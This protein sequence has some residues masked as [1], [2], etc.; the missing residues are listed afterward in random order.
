M[1]IPLSNTRRSMH[2]RALELSRGL[3]PT[4]SNL[5]RVAKEA[6]IEA[7]RWAFSQWDLRGRAR[8]K[9]ARAEEMLFVRE[10]LEQATHERV[11]QYHAAC[12]PPDLQVLDMTTGIGADLIA[13]ARRG[14]AIGYELD[15]ERAELARHNVS[16]HGL[17]VN[18]VTADSTGAIAD[19]D[20]VFVDPARRV[21][22]RRT[23]VLE[24]FAPNPV[25]LAPS[26]A[27]RKLA[28]IKLSPMIKDE[29]LRSLGPAVEFIS[30]GGECREALVLCGTEAGHGFSAVH[31]AS[32][33]RLS[34]SD[35]TLPIESEPGEFIYDADPAAVR[36]HALATLAERHRLGMVGDSNGYLTGPGPITS[37]W[38]RTYRVR[39]A[40]K[41]DL[42]RTRAALKEL[43]AATPEIKQRGA[44]LDLLKERKAYTADGNRPVSLIVYPVG[45][46]LRHVVAEP[47]VP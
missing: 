16:V 36:A 31:I 21:D 46:S 41:A 13:L 37:P 27:S 42:K 11:A 1:A 22:S 26:L 14:P 44:G 4:A 9:F 43:G 2:F 8:T 40:G 28:I 25:L 47:H 18:I 15:P 20:Y 39:Y 38:L 6:G 24:E 45:R 19:F 7:A 3:E 5:Q 35:R 30:F 10:A 29:L 23:L 34:S 12:F 33:E 17:E 32:G